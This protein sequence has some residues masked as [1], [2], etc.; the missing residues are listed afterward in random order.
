M[1]GVFRAV[2]DAQA[3]IHRETGVVEL[4]RRITAEAE[5]I[6]AD[7]LNR[8]RCHHRKGAVGVLDQTDLGI[9]QQ[10][11]GRQRIKVTIGLLH[12]TLAEEHQQFRAR[13][14]IVTRQAREA[15]VALDGDEVANA[16]GKVFTEERE[17]VAFRRTEADQD[18]AR[19]Y[20]N[21]LIHCATGLV[22]AQTKATARTDTAAR[23][24]QVT[25]QHARD[26]SRS[27]DDTTFT[28]R[29]ALATKRHTD[30]RQAQASQL[31]AVRLRDLIESE[32][33]GQLRS[34]GRPDAQHGT[35]TST[36]T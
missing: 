24:R 34:T 17:D 14:H 36:R 8:A 20:R 4:H 10:N 3:L 11:T 15:D 19:S 13:K 1:D 29:K 16:E 28:V 18:I 2:R 9:P 26:T 31:R 12:R 21:R 6:D 32:I 30:I 22:D 25:G 33:T 35:Q 27:D 7:D 5:T 23:D